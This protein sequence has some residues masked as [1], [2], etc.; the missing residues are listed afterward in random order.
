MRRN[1]LF[2]L[3]VVLLMI[4]GVALFLGSHVPVSRPLG[5]G[6]GLVSAYLIRLSWPSGRSGFGTVEADFNS[7]KTGKIPN[8]ALL[9]ASAVSLLAAIVAL[10]CLM[11][12]AAHGYHQVWPVYFFAVVACV[13]TVVWSLLVA[14]TR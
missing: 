9:V 13:C 11:N 3:A 2:A 5:I 7:G 6:A 4:S 14:S 12:D 8:R 10:S 1:G